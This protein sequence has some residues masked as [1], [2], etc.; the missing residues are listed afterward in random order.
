MLMTRAREISWRLDRL[1]DWRRS[2]VADVSHRRNSALAHRHGRS[3]AAALVAASLLI[4]GLA[5][6]D[7]ASASNSCSP[8]GT[9]Y[10]GEACLYGSNVGTN[11]Y[12]IYGTIQ[13]AALS[14]SDPADYFV[15]NDMWIVQSMSTP[16]FIEAGI[17]EGN[18]AGGSGERTVPTFVWG[19]Q[20]PLGGYWS[21]IGGTASLN[22]AYTDEIAYVGFD[23][24][25]ITVGS[26]SGTALSNPMVPTLIRTGT[27]ELNQGATACS[28][29]YNLEYEDSSGT[30]HSGWSSSAQLAWDKPPYAWWVNTDHW[31]RNRS[32]DSTCY[33][34]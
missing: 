33:G 13:S 26:L 34:I 15:D 4:I 32:N 16:I 27:E 17:F 23:E 12:G 2:C 25:S 18:W 24:W 31:V 29:Q 9:N 5:R 19:E 6:V 20:T 14:V 22:T 11:F 7:V 28:E 3:A 21:T 8:Y 1:C 10:Y 30:W